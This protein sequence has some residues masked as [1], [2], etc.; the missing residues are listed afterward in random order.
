M[1]ACFKG[2]L[3]VLLFL[4]GAL[5]PSNAMDDPQQKN[6]VHESRKPMRLVSLGTLKVANSH[7]PYPQGQ[8]P[9]VYPNPKIPFV[10]PQNPNHD[11]MIYFVN[12]D[13]FGAAG[14]LIK[15]EGE[16]QS[17]VAVLNM[18][19]GKWP[20]GGFLNGAN[21][22]EET[23]ARMS[24][25]FLSLMQ[26]GHGQFNMGHLS[27]DISTGKK[28]NYTYENWVS[29]ILIEKGGALYSPGITVFKS[30]IRQ[31]EGGMCFV[32]TDP[33]M[34]NVISSVAVNL[35]KTHHGLNLKQ[36]NPDAYEL[37]M[38]TSIENMLNVAVHTKNDVVVL[39]AFGCGAFGND[40]IEVAQW[41]KGLLRGK[42][43]GYFRKVIF[44]IIADHNDTKG[45]LM[46]FSEVFTDSN[47]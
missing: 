25:L 44:A 17:S 19:N 32:E 46:K 29:K 39:G 20:G 28:S 18:A 43:N 15:E 3:A 24:N 1:V 7:Y 35:G 37:A 21:A 16:K 40:P 30:L 45:N 9:A 42:F 26:R 12:D 13:S 47:L 10:F 2:C 23:L 38:K 31:K 14:R 8:A 41:F 34:V 33:F 27:N 22:Q 11:A 36:A 4:C 6:K 5:V